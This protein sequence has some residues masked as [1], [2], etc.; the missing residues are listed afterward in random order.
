MADQT[1]GYWK[2]LGSLDGR[3]DD[4]RCSNCNSNPRAI[5]T[6]VTWKWEFTPEC[7]WCKTKM[8]GVQPYSLTEQAD[9]E[10]LDKLLAAANSD[11]PVKE[12]DNPLDDGEFPLDITV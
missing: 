6:G 7:P 9:A 1:L 5:P 8:L 3:I 4:Y 10:W 11:E 2:R 12:Q